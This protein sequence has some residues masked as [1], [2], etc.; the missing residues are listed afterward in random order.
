[1]DPLDQLVLYLSGTAAAEQAVARLQAAG[2]PRDPAQHPY[3]T[4]RG[5]VTFLDPDGRRIVLA[6]WVFG[7]EEEPGVEAPNP[8]G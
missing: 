7:A 1:V 3:W 8:P 2:V 6:P 4:A 5:A